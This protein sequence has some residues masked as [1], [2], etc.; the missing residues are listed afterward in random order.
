MP[1]R[2]SHIPH[3]IERSTLQ[4]M[5]PSQGQPIERLHPSGRQTIARMLSK[6][7]I[8]RRS[9]DRGRAVYCITAAGQEALKAPIPQKR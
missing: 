1:A 7:W 9:D 4:R 5:S 2:P 8:E 3:S 6:G